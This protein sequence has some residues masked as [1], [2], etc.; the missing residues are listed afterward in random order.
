MRVTTL[1]ENDRI[2]DRDDLVAEFGLSLH[3]DTGESQVLFDTGTSGAF[4]DNAATLGIELGAVDAAVLSHH[5]F[6]HGGGLERFFAVNDRA[7]V[8]LRQGDLADRYFKGLVVVKRPIGLDLSLFDRFPD[9]F[10]F[11]TDTTEIAPAVFLLTRIPQSHARPKGNSY[12]FVERDGRLCPDP[13]DHELVMVVRNDDGLVV[14]SGCSHN[15]I[16]N[17][18]DAAAQQWPG[19]P[20]RAIIG[21]FHLIGLPI[22]NTMAGSR[23]EVEEIGRC[24]LEFGPGKVYTSHCT[25]EKAFNVLDGVMGETLEAFHT[26]SIIEV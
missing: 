16:L 12:L 3:V 25:G 23:D 2:E 15:G 4:A 19:E 14:F 13:F 18:T 22:I 24:I 5:H 11:I 8:Y 20:I 10:E 26:G 7:K 1:I 17:M 6:D 9:R 21:G